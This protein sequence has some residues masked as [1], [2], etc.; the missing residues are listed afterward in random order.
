MLSNEDPEGQKAF[1]H[2]M[3]CTAVN[4]LVPMAMLY[5]G[6]L[7]PLFIAP[8]YFYQA[9]Y[10]RS[11]LEFKENKASVQSA[12]KLKKKAYMPFIVLLAGFMI[13]TAVERHRKRKENKELM[14]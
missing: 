7:N 4:S 9:Q 12:K 3:A 10:I 13:S 11:V 8:F 6:M 1:S 2:I 14:Q 5:T